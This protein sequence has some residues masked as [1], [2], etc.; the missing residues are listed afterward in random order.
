M[1]WLRRDA[2]AGHPYAVDKM[3]VSTG[4]ARSLT[5]ARRLIAEG[6][7]Y[8]NNE[9]LVPPETGFLP[10]LVITEMTVAEYIDLGIMHD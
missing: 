10:V 4:L 1:L 7:I 2:A 8:V 5:E 9:K 3:L 6:A